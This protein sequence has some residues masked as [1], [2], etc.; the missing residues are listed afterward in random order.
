MVTNGLRR[1]RKNL[2]V[3]QQELATESRVAVCMISQIEKYGY[4]PG[5]NVRHRLAKA[6]NIPENKLWPGLVN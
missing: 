6:L 3:A 5:P 1:W 2:G 4:L